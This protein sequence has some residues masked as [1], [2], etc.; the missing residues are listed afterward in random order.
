MVNDSKR[1]QIL[2]K[3]KGNLISKSVSID[4]YVARS[5]I[6]KHTT[7]L[8]KKKKNNF[9]SL[10]QITTFPYLL[11]LSLASFVVLSMKLRNF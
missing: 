1:V 10:Y 5:M 7:A 3:I 9:S 6:S 4:F 2:V 11:T 8:F